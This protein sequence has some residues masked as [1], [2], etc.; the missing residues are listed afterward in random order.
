MIDLHSH[1]LP[2]CDDGAE[3]LDTAIAMARMAV[4]DGVKIMACTPHIMPGL[5]ENDTAGIQRRVLEF[6]G[7]L[8]DQQIG[9]SLVVG[10]DVHIVP[11]LVEKLDAGVVPTLNGTRYFLFEPPHQVL[12]PNLEK[13]VDRLVDAGYVP[14]LTHPERLGWASRHYDVI[15]RI[16]VAGCLMQVTAGSLTGSFGSRAQKLAEQMFAEGRVDILASDAHNTHTRSPGLSRARHIV[17]SKYGQDVAHDIVIQT[18][19]QIL[20]NQVV[21]PARNKIA[22]GKSEARKPGAKATG[23]RRFV[24]WIKDV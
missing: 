3:D 5:Y 1:L 14:I 22:P 8:A 23:F 9:L 24:E 10:A 17:A 7:V 15:D 21:V 13:L 19:A 2:G 12:P 6:S 11:D 4:A 16:N 18:P 20:R